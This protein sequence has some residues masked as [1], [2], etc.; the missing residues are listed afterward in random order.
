[1]GKNLYVGNLPIN[2]GESDLKALFE[3]HGQVDSVKIIRDYDS[4]RSR[5]FAFVEMA[6]DEAASKAIEALNAH[7]L[8]GR[9]LTVNEARP[10]SDR[11][12]G[13]GGGGKG[14]GRTYSDR[15]RGGPRNRW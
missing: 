4:G 11:R 9:S 8:D 2:L 13:F 12:R 5:G 10:K 1:M 15:G 6:T 7:A 14:G 3:Q